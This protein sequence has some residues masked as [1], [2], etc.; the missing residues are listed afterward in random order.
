MG[1]EGFRHAVTL[2]VRFGET[3]AVG[4]ANNA[5]YLQYLEVARIEYLR[6]AGHS[7]A[8]VHGGGLDMVV[9]EAG[10]RYLRP[11][12]F[13]DEL[14]I[15]CRISELARASFTFQYRLLRDGELCATGFT[16]HACVDTAKMRPVRVPG[17]LQELE[18]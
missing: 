9:V 17:C 15:E 11:V 2:R 1:E 18:G 3:D 10:L 16:R 4:V 5:I 8:E 14:R 12:R 7:Y 6:A 13:D